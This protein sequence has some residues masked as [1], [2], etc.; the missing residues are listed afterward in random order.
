MVQVLYLLE[1]FILAHYGPPSTETPTRETA[2]VRC[3]KNSWIYLTRT[4][5]WWLL[6]PTINIRFN[7]KFQII[8]QLFDSIWKK[9]TIRTALAKIHKSMRGK[10]TV[11]TGR[12][13]VSRSVF[14]VGSVAK[15]S[16]LMTNYSMKIRQSY[17]PFLSSMFCGFLWGI[18]VLDWAWVIVF[19][20]SAVLL[21]HGSPHPQL[22]LR[23]S[24]RFIIRVVKTLHTS[25][26]D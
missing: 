3:H 21:L 13:R 5:C 11:T 10:R 19:Y 26:I 12:W 8:A 7:S 18:P 15:M 20:I 22:R 16:T 4:Y 6:R 17:L 1:V 9:N 2:I 25:N 24:F 14:H 23:S